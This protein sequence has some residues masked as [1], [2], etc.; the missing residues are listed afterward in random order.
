MS[1]L[2][3]S[4]NTYIMLYKFLRIHT[5]FYMTLYSYIEIQQRLMCNISVSVILLRKFELHHLI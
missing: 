4:V 5:S 1:K 3:H 2:N